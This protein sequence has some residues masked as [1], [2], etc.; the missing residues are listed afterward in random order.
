MQRPWS[1]LV[2]CKVAPLLS[3]PS[4]EK[5][6]TGRQPKHA[7][8]TNQCAVGTFGLVRGRHPVQGSI[9]YAGDGEDQACVKGQAFKL[10]PKPSSNMQIN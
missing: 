9:E 7:E 6:A 8:A 1:L 10:E 4:T 5:S 3:G 2:D